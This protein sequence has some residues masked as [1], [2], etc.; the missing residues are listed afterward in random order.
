[1]SFLIN[2]Y[3]FVTAGGGGDPYFSSVTLLLHGEGTNGSTTITDSS[4]YAQTVTAS[5]NAQINTSQFKWGSASINLDGSGDYLT[6]ADTASIDLGSGDWTIECWLRWNSISGFQTL[7][8]H[9]LV[10]SG[11]IVIQTGNGDGKWT[12]Y[13]SGVL[14]VSTSASSPSTGQW[15]HYAFVQNGSLITIYQDGVNVGSGTSSVALSSTVNA[16]IGN[17]V[18]NAAFG[19]NGWVDDVRITK[20]VARYTSNFTPPTAAFPDS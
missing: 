5:G 11:G 13:T 3:R 6:I 2:P 4:S 19:F 1:M 16:G 7:Y 12:V 8:D 20:G 18:S 17:R 14:R 15:Y 9:G 10:A